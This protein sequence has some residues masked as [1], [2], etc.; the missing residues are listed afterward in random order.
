MMNNVCL[1]EY[2]P[3]ATAGGDHPPRCL[4]TVTGCC[5]QTPEAQDVQTCVEL[6]MSCVDIS[7]ALPFQK[8]FIDGT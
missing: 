5:A 3:L 8:N 4:Y 1:L 2:V 7:I 6:L